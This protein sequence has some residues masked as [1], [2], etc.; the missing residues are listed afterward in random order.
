MRKVDKSKTMKGPFSLPAVRYMYGTYGPYAINR[1]SGTL[2]HS[3]YPIHV[4]SK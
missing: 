1:A 2:P 4:E 3:M